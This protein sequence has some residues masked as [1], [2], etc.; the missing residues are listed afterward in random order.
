M[1]ARRITQFLASVT[2]CTLAGFAPVLIGVVAK[3]QEPERHHGF[4]IHGDLKYGPDFPHFDYVNPDAPKGGT[5]T[6]LGRGT[7]DSL[8]PFIIKGTPAG[9]AAAVYDTL[10]T[11]PMDEPNT[12]Y[13][14]LAE[15]ISVSDDKRTVTFGLRPEARFHDGHPV[16]ATDVVWTF[17]T[18][19]EKG[20]PLYRY[21]YS[22]VD[23]AVAVDAHTVEFHLGEGMNQEMPVILGQLP[24]LPEH[25]WADKDF[26]T[27]TLEPPLGSGPYRVADVDAGKAITLERVEDYWGADL[28]VNIG[29]NNFD[30]IVYQYYRDPVVAIE[31]L[32]AGE[33]DIRYEN[34]SKFWA[35]AYDVPAVEKGR[36]IKREFPHHRVAPMQGYI[37]NLR[38]PLFQ[39]PK[40]REALTYLWNFEWVNKTIMYD[41]YV[42]TDSYF[43]N[44][45]L[46]ATGTPGPLE[47]EVLE[48]LRD[49]LP[50]RVFT[51]DYAPPASAPTDM[52]RNNLKAAL[53]L[54][55]EAGWVVNENRKLVH[56]ETGE[57]FAFEILLHSDQFVPHTQSLERA[58]ERLG[59]DVEIRPVDDAQYQN[60][61]DNF[62]FDMTIELFGQSHSPGNEQLDFWGS[63]AAD[64]PG[65]RNAI[66][67][68]NPAIDTLIEKLIASP[69]RETLVA[70][71]KALDR[72]LLWNFYLIPMY[73]SEAD[74]YIYWDKFGIP[75]TVPSQGMTPEIWWV[76]P[77][78]AAALGKAG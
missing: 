21:Y 32:K 41:S 65:S 55:K 51:Q 19:R 10:M 2:L 26:A 43:D 74:R 25:Y 72:A 67:I 64:R 14:L 15:W 53:G 52:D 54:L 34:S 63:A 1:N 24:V 20:A 48:P 49:Q 62:D 28:P 22:A 4:A 58:V 36:L 66:G 27:T 42:R 69:D 18:L 7:F 61:V 73:H 71:T 31:A 17:D 78:K 47:M 77:E 9:A 70:R 45:D 57:P 44:S 68:K 6:R 23:K 46:E 11:Q 38:R 3:A 56:G 39:D 5:V 76:D 75:E 30:R 29:I 59:G 33:I 37:F 50:P 60:R 12:E 8:N 13:G 40:V 35:T 16:E